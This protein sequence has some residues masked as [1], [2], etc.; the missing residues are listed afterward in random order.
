MSAETQFIKTPRELLRSGLPAG[1]VTLWTLICFHDWN[2]PSGVDQPTLLGELGHAAIVGTE[3]GPRPARR[4]LT[5]WLKLLD[6]ER[7][8]GIKRR[9]SNNKEGDLATR[10]FYAPQRMIGDRSVDKR[11]YEP[12]ETQ[13]REDLAAGRIGFKQWVALLCWY[14]ACGSK[15]WTEGSL[16]QHAATYK[17]SPRAASKWRAQLVALGRLEIKQRPGKPAITAKPGC[18]P[19]QTPDVSVPSVPQTPDVSVPSV[20][21]TPDVSV[22]SVP[23]TPDVSVPSPLTFLSPLVPQS[24]TSVLLPQGEVLPPGLGVQKNPDETSHHPSS[25]VPRKAANG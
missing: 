19:V 12:M 13:D 2:N 9:Y 23:Q 24:G 3:L 14:D 11:S 17:I 10:N 21:Q 16:K 7:W 22:P 25:S 5:R 15:G 18:L 8:L 1:A 4:D 6:A 20:P